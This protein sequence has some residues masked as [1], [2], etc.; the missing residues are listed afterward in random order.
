[1]LPFRRP[2]HD[3]LPGSFDVESGAIR[4]RRNR[5]HRQPWTAATRQPQAAKKP[6]TG[7]KERL[8]RNVEL[9]AGGATSATGGLQSMIEIWKVWACQRR[10]TTMLCNHPYEWA[11]VA[12]A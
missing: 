2:H 3:E 6:A 9:S 8:P 11:A 5:S 12:L 10:A 1:M 7:G 4:C